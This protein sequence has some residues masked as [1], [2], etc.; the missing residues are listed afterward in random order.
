MRT[1][2]SNSWLLLVSTVAFVVAPATVMAGK[3]DDAERAQEFFDRGAQYYFEEEYSKALVEFYRAQTAHEHPVFKYNIA[4]S[5]LRLG[6]LENAREA[7]IEAQAMDEAPSPENRANTSSIVVS[8]NT[9][10]HAGSVAEAVAQADEAVDED[11][12]D[13]D[14]L[15]GDDLDDDEIDEDLLVEG[16]LDEERIEKDEDRPD[17]EVDELAVRERDDELEESSFGL[18]G[19]TGIGSLT[20]A[21]ASLG[22]A[23]F[24]NRQINDEWAELK[25]KEAGEIDRGSFEERREDIAGLQTRGQIL[26]FSGVGLATLGT[27]LVVTDL[28]RGGSNETGDLAL[29]PSVDRPAINLSVRW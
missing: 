25:A 26:L 5:Y 12:F 20:I 13:E 19:W 17:D 22:G 8:V 21:A 10:E 6:Q 7:A 3:P 1:G 28:V 9:V 14:L 4:M 15:V 18:L 23:V 2:N 29:T 24:T 11:E 27:T 16:E